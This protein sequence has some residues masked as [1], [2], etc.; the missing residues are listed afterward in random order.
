[1]FG[2]LQIRLSPEEQSV[3]SESKVSDASSQDYGSY[4]SVLRDFRLKPGRFPQ[5]A[6]EAGL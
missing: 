2:S 1:M 3:D 6:Q 4:D 5:N